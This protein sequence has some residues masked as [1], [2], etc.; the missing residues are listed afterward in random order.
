M[1]G[2]AVA[3]RRIGIGDLLVAD[4]PMTI[5]GKKSGQAGA[6]TD[7]PDDSRHQD[8]QRKGRVEKEDRNE[9]RRRNTLQDVVSERAFADPNDR[10]QHDR[11][12]GRLEAEEHG[13]HHADIA[14]GGIDP[15]QNHEGNETW[16]NEEGPGDES[17]PGL[18]QQPS[19]V[20]RELLRLRPGQQHAVVQGVK[21]P[22]VADPTLLLDQDPVHHRDLPRRSAKA[23]GRDFDPYPE[24]L[25]E[26]NA[27]GGYALLG[28][29]R[30]DQSLVHRLYVSDR[31]KKATLVSYRGA[32]YVA[33]LSGA[34]CP[35]APSPPRCKLEGV[36]E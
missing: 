3:E 19:N 9:R 13:L 33:I 7:E 2:G 23:Q 29:G 8:D 14:E 30:L 36:A 1:G 12:H 26:G 25:A 34:R 18:M 17:A 28:L 16:E 4:L 21:K 31:P 10:L 24:G 35:L 22:G 32:A 27:M 20:D 15:T 6:P 5:A 11:E